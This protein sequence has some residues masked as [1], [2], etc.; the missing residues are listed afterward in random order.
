MARKVDIRGDRS[1]HFPTLPDASTIT[2]ARVLACR[3][4]VWDAIGGLTS[5][6]SL[7]VV[8][9]HGPDLEALRPLDR[10]EQLRIQHMPKVTSL[11]G[12]EG[13]TS[14]RRL[15]LETLPSWD[16]SKVTE[17]E[18]LAPLRELPI[19]ELNM[20]GVRPASRSVE[21]LLE[22]P[23]L[24]KARLSTF[25]AREIKR[26]N[27]VLPDEYVTSNRHQLPH[28][29]LNPIKGP[30][31]SGFAPGEPLP[32]RGAPAGVAVAGPMDPRAVESK[33]PRKADS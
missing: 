19:E 9:W 22:I 21:E 32:E 8:D 10:L 12:L 2:H 25:A 26:I 30:L 31:I 14:L 20:F 11:A 28:T 17:V 24:R 4:E 23:T 13:L 7:E 6:T 27:D 1:E 33:D 16:G 5:L 15:V 29:I 18:S 3:Y